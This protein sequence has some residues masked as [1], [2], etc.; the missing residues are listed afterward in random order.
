MRASRSQ[1]EKARILL[2][3]HTGGGMLLLPNVWNPIGARVL[4]K[5]GYPAVATASAAISASLGYRDGEKIRRATMLDL[6]GRIARSVA[7]PVTADIEAGYAAT[8]S[9]LEES[10]EQVIDCGVVGVNIEDS[11]GGE[12]NLRAVDAQCERI[13]TIRETAE[14]LG[15]HLVIN[16]RT[17]IFL[18][19]MRADGE[20]AMEETVTRA[21]AYAGAGANCVYPVGPGDEVTVRRLRERIASPLNILGSPSAAPLAVLRAIGVNRVSFGPYVFRSLLRKFSDIADALLATGDCAFLGDMM[22][23][24]ETGTFLLDGEEPC[25]GK[26]VST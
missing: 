25:A 10:I 5:K 12:G 14:R 17:D 23:R 8:L 18:S 22:S 3:L 6:V 15:L 1:K 13:A 16:A 9:E 4:E 19:P 26:G 2:S 21:L 24:E 20:R 7:V 11:V